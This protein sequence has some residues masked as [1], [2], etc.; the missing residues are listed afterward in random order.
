MEGTIVASLQQAEALRQSILKKAF[1]GRFLNDKELEAVR[2]DPT[3]EPAE[4]L[5]E[6]IR[7]E[8]AVL[9]SGKKGRKSKA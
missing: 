9:H 6:R 7:T 4:R 5:L 1:E 3:W 2:K 8:R